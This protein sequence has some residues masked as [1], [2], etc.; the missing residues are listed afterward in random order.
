MEHLLTPDVT[1]L[2]RA[3]C[4][5]SLPALMVVTFSMVSEGPYG[6]EELVRKT[7]FQVAALIPLIPPFPLEP[8]HGPEA[9]RGALR[10]P[11][12]GESLTR[13]P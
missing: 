2:S 12:G 11:G 13:A 1:A 7:G 10:D 4:K 5:L 6:L 9:R 8:A 3:L